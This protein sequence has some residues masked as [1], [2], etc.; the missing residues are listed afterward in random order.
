M[1][2]MPMNFQA[3]TTR[4]DYVSRHRYTGMTSLCTLHEVPVSRG[5]VRG[6]LH[7]CCTCMTGSPKVRQSAPYA[8]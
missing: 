3:F 4:R 2:S 8:A 5:D 6:V 1:I 7:A